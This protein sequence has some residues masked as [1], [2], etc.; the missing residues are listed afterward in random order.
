MERIPAICILPH[1][2]LMCKDGSE[3]MN[4]LYTM[5]S[6]IS[7]VENGFAKSNLSWDLGQSIGLCVLVGSSYNFF[8]GTK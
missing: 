8:G 2:C 4:L 7:S 5:S 6:C 3:C 1:V